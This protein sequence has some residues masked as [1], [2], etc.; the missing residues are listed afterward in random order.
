M[1]RSGT[2]C[3]LGAGASADAGYPLATELRHEFF[4]LVE[5]EGQREAELCRKRAEQLK[6]SENS[7]KMIL[8]LDQAEPD[9]DAATISDKFKMLWAVYEECAASEKLLATPKF[10]DGRPELNSAVRITASGIAFAPYSLPRES[11]DSAPPTLEGFFAFYDLLERPI[12]RRLFANLRLP[13]GTAAPQASAVPQDFRSLRK[14]ALRT[15]YDA[16]APFKHEL[17]D[18]LAPLLSVTGPF[19]HPT[20]ATLNFDLAIEQV[21]SDRELTVF[22]GFSDAPRLDLPRPQSF[23]QAESPNLVRLWDTARSNLCPYIGFESVPS[24]S[25][26][27]IKLHGSLGWFTIEEGSGDIGNRADLRRNTVYA[28]MRLPLEVMA[29]AGNASNIHDLAVGGAS[30]I[31]MQSSD[32]QVSRKAGVIWLRP[33]MMFARATKMHLDAMWVELVG[34]LSLSLTYAQ[35][36]LVV[37]YSWGDAHINDIL[38][39]AIAQGARLIDV[40][41]ECPNQHTLGL[42]AQRFPTTF[43]ETS[44]RVFMFGGGSRQVLAE[45]EIVLPCGK[46]VSFDLPDALTRAIALPTEYSLRQA[47]NS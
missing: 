33:N 2:F 12:L 30:D 44:D 23:E 17:A 42:I 26:E 14:I 39:N 11:S 32:G 40:S 36:I 7:L 6:R 16:L 18:Y 5:A 10:V 4:E 19:G 21:V 35:N 37:G 29:F 28:H 38:L 25:I 1:A 31:T 3:L 41:R 15:A 47:I 20:I 46:T 34:R 24:G 43:R 13:K 27:L 45:R 8:P 22:D 9:L